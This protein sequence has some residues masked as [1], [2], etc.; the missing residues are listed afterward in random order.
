MR[1]K[2]Y[3]LTEKQKNWLIKNFKNTKN[4]EIAEKLGISKRSIIRFARAL[5][6][7]KSPQFLKKM[8][9]AALNAANTA[10]LNET[11]EQREKR[12]ITA[13]KNCEKGKIAKGEYRNAQKT[14]AE[15]KKIIKK[16]VNTWRKNRENEISRV[17]LGLN[18][19]TKVKLPK[20][21]NPKKQ[22]QIINIR[23]NLRKKGYKI[24]KIGGMAVHI[25]EDTKRS[26]ITENNAK[27]LGFIFKL[28]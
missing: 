23:H 3:I 24:P 22:Q 14:K 27:K 8:R 6:L 5:E 11:P 20:D 26:E 25:T 15:I 28:I 9:T 16:R 4:D 13:L 2:K 1:G 18:Q 12:R 17:L 21:F 10:I 7:V 19:K